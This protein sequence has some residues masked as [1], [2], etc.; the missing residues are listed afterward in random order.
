MSIPVASQI[1]HAVGLGMAATYRKTDE[2]VMSIFGDGATSEGDFHE[3]LNCASVFQ[4][5][6]IFVCQ[7]NQWAISLPINKQMHSKTIV[8]KAA[9]YDMPGIQVDGNDI[10]AVYS[11]A[12][13]AAD[14][15]RRGDGP[16]FIECVTYRIMMHTTADDPSRYRLNEDV[17][18]WIK[19]DPIPRFA[20][21]LHKKNIL[22]EDENKALEKE[23]LAE[24]QSSVENAEKTMKNIGNPLEMFDH[25]YEE[26]PLYAQKQKKELEGLLAASG[27][28][29]H[30]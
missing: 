4:S 22:S 14:K 13:E 27:E 16:T 25:L 18:K 6:V 11:A 29:N 23:I 8:Q 9:A 24:I 7:N 3:A 1:L 5:P 30:G 26:L 28:K 12:R 10:L 2:I 19:K 20:H 21:Y 17:E 15:A